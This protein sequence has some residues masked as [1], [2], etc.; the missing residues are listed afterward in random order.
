[1]FRIIQ[2][3]MSKQDFGV[4]VISSLGMVGEMVP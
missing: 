2:S 3:K 1:M 4:G